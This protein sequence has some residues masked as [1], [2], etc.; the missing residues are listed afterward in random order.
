MQMTL[1]KGLAAVLTAGSFL[2]IAF[3]AHAAKLPPLNSPYTVESHPG[4]FVWAELFTSD[5]AAASKFY[6]GV[7]GWSAATIVQRGVTYTVFSSD[8]RPVAGLR[9]RPAGASPHAS[10]WINYVAVTDVEAV[11]TAVTK[12]GGVIR[13]PARSFPDLGMQAIVTDTEGSPLGLLE[14]SSGD[15]ADREPPAGTWNWFHLFVKQPQAAGEFYRQIL[16]YEVTPDP[17]IGKKDQLLLESDGINRAGISVLPDREDAK[18]GWL[19][20]IRVA[21]LDE[22]LARVPA[23]GGEVMV[24]PHGA[25]LGSRFAVIADPTGGTVGLVQYLN[26]NNP[27]SKP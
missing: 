1:R 4:K 3:C 7:L 26:N 12:A 9:Q 18:P 6:T 23:L 14:S 17:R 20:V 24:A 10:R 21:N 22:V 8:G 13:A 11:L 25:S 16:N 15:P 2:G 27:V 19:G 5:T